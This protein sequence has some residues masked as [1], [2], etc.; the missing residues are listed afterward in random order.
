[1]ADSNYEVVMNNNIDNLKIDINNCIQNGA[2]IIGPV[3]YINNNYVQTVTRRDFTF[4]SN[5]HLEYRVITG[6]TINHLHNNVNKVLNYQDQRWHCIDGA[7]LIGG[8]WTQTLVK[9]WG[10]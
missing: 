8:F 7:C 3:K 1:M 5:T 6:N 10:N 4:S 9:I 2:H